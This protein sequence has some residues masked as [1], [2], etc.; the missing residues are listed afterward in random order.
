MTLIEAA[1]L[2][3]ICDTRRGAS[4]IADIASEAG[5]SVQAAGRSVRRLTKMGVAV[6]AGSPGGWVVRSTALGRRVR[7]AG[8]LIDA[9][10]S[11][12]IKPKMRLNPLREAGRFARTVGALE[13]LAGLAADARDAFWVPYARVTCGDGL[14]LG[15]LELRRRIQ[16]DAAFLD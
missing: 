6:L 14:E 15:C 4:S 9:V 12:P 13:A 3:I 10:S 16:V 7:M 2:E 11:R 8:E 5:T 1:I